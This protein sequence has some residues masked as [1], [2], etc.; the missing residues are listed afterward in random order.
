M[1]AGIALHH[2]I[3]GPDDAP[4]LVLGPSLGTDLHLFDAQVAAFADRY[5]TLRFDLPGHGGTPAVDGPYTMAGL[6]QSVV[7]LLD[8]LDIDR[9]HYAG[10]SIGG[11]I[12]QQLALDHPGRVLSLTAMASAARFADPAAWPGRAATV[13]ENGTEAMVASRP[14]TWFVHSF[15]GTDEAE[16][17]LAMLRAT[18]AEGYAGCCEAISTFDLRDRL[19]AIA[20]PVLAIAGA[21]DPATPPDMVRVI[22]DGAPD[23]RFETVADSAHLLNAEKPEQVNELLAAHL[24]S[25]GADRR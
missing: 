8:R 3:D 7:A 13:R 10:V 25:V 11:A 23:G 4:V 17:L 2:R 22:A 15:A 12:G 6:A 1:T 20:V 5:R 19:G 24:A 9:V 21:D 14:G 18:A 16:R